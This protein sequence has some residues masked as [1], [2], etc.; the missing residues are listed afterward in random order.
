MNLRVPPRLRLGPTAALVLL[1]GCSLAFARQKVVS[2][3][4]MLEPVQTIANQLRKI[5]A[6]VNNDAC[7]LSPIRF[8]A[9]DGFSFSS[10]IPGSLYV[11]PLT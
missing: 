4:T 10:E 11:R 6:R 3:R 5:Q 2:F 7:H 8:I 1:A 9:R